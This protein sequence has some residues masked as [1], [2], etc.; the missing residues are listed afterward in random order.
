MILVA[1]QKDESGENL[2][3]MDVTTVRFRPQYYFPLSRFPRPNLDYCIL[4]N[5][6]GAVVPRVAGD[7][8]QPSLS[9]LS[10]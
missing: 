5:F 8:R 3:K 4:L 7:E 9:P 10:L 6:E 1:A 2:V